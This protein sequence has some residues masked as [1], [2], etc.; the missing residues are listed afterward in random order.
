MQQISHSG[1]LD[2]IFNKVNFQLIDVRTQEE[3]EH[4]NVGGIN[5][6]L[7]DLMRRSD[8]IQQNIPVIFYCRK[9]IRSQLAIQRLLEKMPEGDFYNLIGGIGNKK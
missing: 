6:P 7:D 9:G 3:H 8:E 1:L 4:H 5:I 2:L